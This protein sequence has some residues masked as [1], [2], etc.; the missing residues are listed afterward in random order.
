MHTGI[1]IKADERFRVRE[2]RRPPPGTFC[3]QKIKVTKEL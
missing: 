2:N 1:W 3:F